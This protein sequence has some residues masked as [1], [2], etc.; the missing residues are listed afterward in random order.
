MALL[1]RMRE[2]MSDQPRTG[3]RRRRIAIGAEN[4]MAA[5]G[6][7]GSIDPRS[8]P[9]GL[10]TGMHTDVGE[11]GGETRSQHGAGLGGERLA[12]LVQRIAYD[13]RRRP[14]RNGVAA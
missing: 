8:R 1:H 3:S 7:G 11:I 12:W 6:E 13:R 4:D 10:G 2:L 14:C 9:R 5:H